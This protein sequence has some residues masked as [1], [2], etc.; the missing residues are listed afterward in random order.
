MWEVIYDYPD[1]PIGVAIDCGG[2]LLNNGEVTYVT[3]A[4]ARAFERKT[5]NKLKTG[6]HF[7]NIKKSKKKKAG[8][9]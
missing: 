2:L 3:E 9:N 4:Q 1:E 5:G 7:T 8:E 6:G